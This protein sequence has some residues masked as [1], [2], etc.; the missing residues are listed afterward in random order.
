M[1]KMIDSKKPTSKRATFGKAERD[2]Q[3]KVV[4]PF[5]M[6]EHDNYGKEGKG[7]AAYL[8]PSYTLL[9]G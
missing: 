9:N 4:E 5:K 1:G 7:P 8:P 6:A 2:S 3:R